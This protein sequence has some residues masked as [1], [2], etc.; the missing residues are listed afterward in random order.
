M[1]REKILCLVI[2]IFLAGNSLK[3]SELT[4]SF[5]KLNKKQ[6]I[7]LLKDIIKRRPFLRSSSDVKLKKFTIGKFFNMEIYKKL[8]GNDILGYEHD[9]GFKNESSSVFIRTIRTNSKTAPFRQQF[10]RSL[11]N[12]IRV[13]K[14]RISKVSRIEMGIGLLDVE[15]EKTSSSLPG[16]L[17]EIYFKNKRSGKYFYYRFSTGKS[18]GLRDV[19]N[20]IWMLTFSVLES[21]R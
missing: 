6:K 21:L 7:Q 14:V 3:A 19:F 5:N 15:P 16:A 20:N 18:S 1:K 2:M 17:V 8:E 9:E 10:I 11:N 13:K 4:G 12:I